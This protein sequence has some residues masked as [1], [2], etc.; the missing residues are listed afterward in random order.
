MPGAPWAPWFGRGGT[1][2]GVVGNGCDDG[3]IRRCRCRNWHGLRLV[4]GFLL[5]RKGQRHGLGFLVYF[6]LVRELSRVLLAEA[7]R[8]TVCSDDAHE[9]VWVHWGPPVQHVLVNISGVHLCYFP[10][11]AM[12][13][14]LPAHQHAV[15]EYC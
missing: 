13:V 6:F 3:A 1:C 15:G 11:R 5:R 8:E 14:W 9:T 7:P 12:L 2:A 10:Y 4:V